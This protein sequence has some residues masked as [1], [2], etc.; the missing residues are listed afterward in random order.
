MVLVDEFRTELAERAVG[1]RLTHGPGPAA[2]AIACFD[3]RDRFAGLYELIRDRQAG[4]PGAGND[5]ALDEHGHLIA[6][7]VPR[8]IN[9]C[10]C[11]RRRPAQLEKRE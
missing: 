9:S 3:E 4:Q 10:E 6:A 5:D 7:R 11:R 2:D 1:E 8:I